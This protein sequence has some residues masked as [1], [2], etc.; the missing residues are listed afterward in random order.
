L[1]WQP[2]CRRTT[3]C[4][5][6]SR[7]GRIP[8]CWRDTAR[9][10]TGRYGDSAIRSTRCGAVPITTRLANRP[11]RQINTAISGRCLSCLASISLGEPSSC[12]SL[13]GCRSEPKTCHTSTRSTGR[14]SES[15]WKWSSSRCGWLGPGCGHSA[16]RFG[17]WS[18]E[19]AQVPS[20][21]PAMS[22]GM[23][24]ASRQRNG[25]A[26]RTVPEP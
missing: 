13:P 16:S 14:R 3:S 7:G 4:P 11:A 17:S 15:S 20:L 8:R 10:A 5:I 18:T 6:G 22:L 1:E 12:P 24:V 19:P 2:S 25:A 9:P 23:T 21:K 26:R